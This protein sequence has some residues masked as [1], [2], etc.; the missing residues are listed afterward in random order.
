MTD[1]ALE[2]YRKRIEEY[3]RIFSFKASVSC[4]DVVSGVRVLV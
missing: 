2:E 1:D 4:I 3:E